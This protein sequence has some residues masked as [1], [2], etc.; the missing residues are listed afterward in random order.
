MRGRVLD[1]EGADPLDEA[2]HAALL[3]DAHQRRAQRLGGIGGHLGH[4]GLGAIAL[5]DVA[6]SNLAELEVAGDVGGH[7]DVSELARGDEELGNKVDVPVV[8][9]AVLGPGLL[10]A[11]K[12]AVLVVE[13]AEGGC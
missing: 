12:V 3:K 2:L 7:E 5:L 1:V 11:G 6:A 13:L 8:D 9:A 10:A 4:G